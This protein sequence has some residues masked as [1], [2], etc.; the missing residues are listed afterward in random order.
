MSTQETTASSRL[1][2]EYVQF[3]LK[4]CFVLFTLSLFSFSDIEKLK[5]IQQFRKARAHKLPGGY[6]TYLCGL[7]YGFQEIHCPQGIVNLNPEEDFSDYSYFSTDDDITIVPRNTRSE[8]NKEYG[9]HIA[10][11]QSSPVKRQSKLYTESELKQ[12]RAK[13]CTGFPSFEYEK[14]FNSKG[15][16]TYSPKRLGKLAHPDDK[17]G[18]K[19]LNKSKKNNNGNTEADKENVNAKHTTIK[20]D[21]RNPFQA[22]IDNPDVHYKI[23]CFMLQHGDNTKGGAISNVIKARNREEEKGKCNDKDT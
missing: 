16:L 23:N 7:R 9:L 2:L 12:Q 18:D 10:L 15:I 4:N 22:C 19:V 11:S 14:G 6:K 8:P 13:V 17:A 5:T 3:G 1:L 20:V 21:Y